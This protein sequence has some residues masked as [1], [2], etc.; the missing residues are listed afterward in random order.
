MVRGHHEP[1]A[2]LAR[3]QLVAFGRAAW[4]PAVTA[5]IRQHHRITPYRGPHAWLVEPFRRADWMDVTVGPVA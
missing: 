5:A 2:R 3:E 4:V 1:S